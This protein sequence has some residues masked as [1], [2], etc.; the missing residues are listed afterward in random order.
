MTRWKES[1]S[2]FHYQSLLISGAERRIFLLVHNRE[3]ALIE[4]TAVGGCLESWGQIIHN[5]TRMISPRGKVQWKVPGKR[6]PCL[7]ASAWSWP[8]WSCPRTRSEG[9]RASPAL[10]APAWPRGT[11]SRDCRNP[12]PS[13]VGLPGRS[14]APAQ[15]LL[16]LS[17]SQLTAG[18]KCC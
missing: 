8:E 1:T 18:W 15:P 6:S 14:R 10:R 4:I 2:L 17:S 11:G 5:V 9:C 12:Q 16:G 13:R 7:E 3:M